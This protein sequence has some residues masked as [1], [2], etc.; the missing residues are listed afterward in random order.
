VTR[1]EIRTEKNPSP[2]L[3]RRLFLLRPLIACL[4]CRQRKSNCHY[5]LF[6]SFDISSWLSSW[7]FCITALLV[8]DLILIPTFSPVHLFTFYPVGRLS[9]SRKSRLQGR[10]SKQNKAP[11]VSHTRRTSD[12]TSSEF[13][14]IITSY[15]TSHLHPC[16]D[17]GQPDRSCRSR[18]PPRK[19]PRGRPPS[20]FYKQV[21]PRSDSFLLL[22]FLDIFP[23]FRF[24]L[25]FPPLLTSSLL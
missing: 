12:S 4:F 7:S 10:D 14:A 11:P 24:N 22:A 18:E 13:I 16:W 8:I 21:Q 15:A 5:I 2:W 25:L 1:P 20:F 3:A 9:R 17:T 23:L 19:E 6:F